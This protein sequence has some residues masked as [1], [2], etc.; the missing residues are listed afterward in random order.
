MSNSGSMNRRQLCLSGLGLAASLTACAPKNLMSASS[1]TLSR[2][3][4]QLYSIR[5]SFD[6][7][8]F[9][10]LALVKAAGYAEVEFGGGV[11]WDLEPSKLSDELAKND[12]TAPSLHA[13]P[14]DLTDRMDHV[15][16]MA[17]GVGAEY[18]VLP[19]IPMDMRGSLEAWPVMARLCNETAQR[20]ADAG[21]AFAYHN[22]AYE[23]I[24]LEGQISGFE[25]FTAETDPDLVKLELDL[26][27][28]AKAGV[29]PLGLF[30]RFP[31]RISLCHA[32]DMDEVGQMCLPGEGQIDFQTIFRR[33]RQA[34]LKHFFVEHDRLVTADVD[35]MR[36]ARDHLY[37]MALS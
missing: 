5:D 28:L 29:D 4:V 3:G 12:L 7:A 17:K 33:S 36:A 2:I 37:G 8:P 23:F 34:G 11:F 6:A 31:G 35:R 13:G 20:L 21:L 16:R 10:T 9:E 15:I 14:T 25:I 27:W 1:D 19:G 26:Y 30:E 24:R 18:V 22:H 32:K